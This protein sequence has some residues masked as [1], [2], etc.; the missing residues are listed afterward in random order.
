MKI[1]VRHSLALLKKMSPV[2]RSMLAFLLGISIK[3]GPSSFIR[4]I[5][6]ITFASIAT[7]ES[8]D[9]KNYNTLFSLPV[10]RLELAKAK[11]LTLL[12]VYGTTTFLSIILYVIYILLGFTEKTGILIIMVQLL[13]TF[14]LSVFLGLVG[15][16]VK[17]TFPVLIIIILLLN[18]VHITSVTSTLQIGQNTII[19]ILILLI[20]LG[21]SRF[22][23]NVV[24]ENIIKFYSDMEL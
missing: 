14:L 8:Y 15:I 5:P 7:I 11:L 23:Y 16:A 4:V 20:L 2:L 17:N 9:D 24:K 6:I 1:A 13:A 10:N 3:N 19:D 22:V 18:S 21:F 12:I